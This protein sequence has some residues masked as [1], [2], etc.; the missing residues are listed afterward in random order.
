M[1]SGVKDPRWQA[2]EP[3]IKRADGAS[4]QSD[5]T[6][7]LVPDLKPMPSQFGVESFE[8]LS[9][10]YFG[11]TQERAMFTSQEAE[12]AVIK[13]LSKG[14]QVVASADALEKDMSALQ[15][16]LE[17]LQKEV[18]AAAQAGNVQKLNEITAKFGEIQK[19][20]TSVDMTAMNPTKNST[21][22]LLARDSATKR[23]TST[24][25]IQRDDA[26]GETVVTFWREGGW[27]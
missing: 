21:A 15:P 11:S 19:K 14:R 1:L 7:G 8:G 3:W 12:A 20:M 5:A 25:T 13:R 9:F 6:S 24:A 23:P 17:A 22:I 4:E 16:T 2:L 18:M 27:R 10:R 26:L